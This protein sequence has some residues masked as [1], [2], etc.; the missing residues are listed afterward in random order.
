MKF[1]H[2]GVKK[3]NETSASEGCL[4]FIGFAALIFLFTL[5]DDLDDLSDHFFELIAVFFM[6]GSVLFAIFAKKGKLSNHHITLKNEYLQIGKV[7]V[8]LENVI[9][10]IYKK[11]DSF[12]RY[13][14]R[15]KEGKIAVFSVLK[16]DLVEHFLKELSNQV[17][18]FQEVSKNHDGAYITVNAESR[19]LYY[20]LNRGKYTINPRKQTEISVVPDVYTY[21][22]KYKLGKPLLK[23][24][25]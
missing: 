14:L 16:D 23:K 15:D 11:E 22:P 2:K 9:L 5:I 19:N 21:D 18:E 12:V 1:Y 25:K 10:D 17:F 13:H 6:G 8:P 7:N 4:L 24:K 3:S 20:D